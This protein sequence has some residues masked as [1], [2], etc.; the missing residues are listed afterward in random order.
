MNAYRAAIPF[1]CDHLS[2][3]LCRE[4]GRV[5]MLQSITPRNQCL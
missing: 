2:Q 4:D 3:E 1:N 5:R